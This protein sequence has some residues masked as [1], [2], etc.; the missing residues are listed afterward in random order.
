MLKLVLSIGTAMALVG[1]ATV[2]R[3][4]Q[5]DVKIY[6]SPEDA[7]VITSNGRTCTQSPCILKM[8]RKESFDVIASKTGY[9]KKVVAVTS[10][11]SG[12]GAA[13][14]AGNVL[15][16]GVIGIGVDAISGASRD[17][18]PNP[19]LIELVPTNPKDPKTPKGDL[20]SVRAEIEAK[21]KEQSDAVARQQGS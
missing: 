12:K 21:K 8:P 4:T 19:V 15:V 16:G 7:Q 6:Y 14:M 9:V 2:T 10:S 3:G 1:C 18:Y 11:V 17:H 20:S 5:D 13:G